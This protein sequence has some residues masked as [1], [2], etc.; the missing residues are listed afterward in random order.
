M[1]TREEFE[2]IYGQ[3]NDLTN[4]FTELNRRMSPYY[5]RESLEEAEL[6]KEERDVLVEKLGELR[7]DGAL[8]EAEEILTIYQASVLA[9]A[10]GYGI[11]PMQTLPADSQQLSPAD[12]GEDLV[13]GESLSDEEKGLAENLVGRRA[14]VK[15][16]KPSNKAEIEEIGPGDGVVGDKVKVPWDGVGGFFSVGKTGWKK[17]Q[18]A[19]V[20]TT[21]EKFLDS[22]E[23]WLEKGT[24]VVTKDEY[25]ALEG[26]YYNYIY[27][28]RWSFGPEEFARRLQKLAESRGLEFIVTPK[29]E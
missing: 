16:S 8:L 22:L 7:T 20:I 14:T 6:S 2:V 23:S 12:G 25:E 1:V 11:S 26:L 27:A 19:G 18:E 9:R 28:L 15:V 3:L 17:L 5:L 4:K 13:E 29:T 10:L 24:G 21:Y